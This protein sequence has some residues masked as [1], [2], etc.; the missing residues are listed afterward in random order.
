M[1]RKGEQKVA[2][3][4]KHTTRTHDIKSTREMKCAVVTQTTVIIIICM[5]KSIRDE[6]DDHHKEHT[7]KSPIQEE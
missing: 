2:T 6:D 1:V 4:K 7:T 5:L 3:T